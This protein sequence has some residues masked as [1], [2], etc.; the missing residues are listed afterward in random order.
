MLLVSDPALFK[1]LVPWLG[2]QPSWLVEHRRQSVDSA[3][4]YVRVR[5][6]LRALRGLRA[7]LGPFFFAVRF[8]G[9][10]AALLAG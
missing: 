4:M 6:T 7:S 10:N 1:T 3:R 5:D 2:T 8:L 9:R